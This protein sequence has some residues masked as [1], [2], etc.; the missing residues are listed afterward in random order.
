M[1]VVS[2]AGAGDAFLAGFI[3]G[4]CCGLPIFKGFNDKHL[5]ATPLSS[6]VELGILL[7][8]LAVTSQDSIH[9]G[10]NAQLLYDLIRK[11]NLIAGDNLSKIFSACTQTNYSQLLN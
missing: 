1:P 8:S 11:N 2:T 6:A 10:A 4:I 5:G 3:S 9:A 7:A